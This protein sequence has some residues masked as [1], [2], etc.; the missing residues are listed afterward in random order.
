MGYLTAAGVESCIQWLNGAYP[1]I[2]Q[3]MILPETSI[4]GR[5]IRALKIAKGGGERHGIAFLGGVHARE[6]VNPDLL[7]SFAL[8][9]CWAYTNGAGLTYGGQTYS[10]GTVALLVEGLDIWIL[11]LV[12]PDGRSYVQALGGD[13]WWRKNRR[14]TGACTGIDLNR[15]FD[16][17]WTSGIG[18]SSDPCDYQIYKGSSAFS[19]P[20]TRNVQA[21][22]DAQPNIHCLID[23]H[24]Y[25]EDILYSWGDDNDQTTNPSENFRNPA[26]DGLRGGLTAVYGEFI[27]SSDRDWYISTGNSV[28][29]AIAAVRG[30]TYTVKQSVDLY[31][32]TAT[33]DDYAYSR[34]F[35]DATK[36][37]VRSY[38]LETGK[39]FQ[40]PYAEALEII[41]EVSAGLIRFCTACLCAVDEM[42]K[43]QRLELDVNALRNFRDEHLAR[44]SVGNRWI[45]LLEAHGGEAVSIA[46]DD[47]QLRG[48]AARVLHELSAAVGEK[49]AATI[50]PALVKRAR[51]VLNALHERASPE[52]RFGLTELHEGLEHFAGVTPHEGLR[53][54][55]RASKARA[56]SN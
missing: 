52:L 10:S 48:E 2:T 42:A 15:N 5:T 29:T 44:S 45:A 12:N 51:A 53:A 31:P 26:Y 1:A 3:I 43:S 46:L 6:L 4:E 11:P 36:L 27:S 20:E 28:S 35:V 9:L 39:I 24:S 50:D 34:T 41:R 23:V 21:L 18:T 37:K 32:T 54:A 14:P 25:S 33:S 16:F 8:D 7:L 22:L 40:P 56:G 47:H 49:P 30:T 55:E 13:V 38:T 17:L 19:E